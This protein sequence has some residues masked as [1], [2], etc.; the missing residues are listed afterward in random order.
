MPLTR[1]TRIGVYE[2]LQALGAGGM[3]EVY[4]ARDTRLDRVVALK[5]L[6]PDRVP[7]DDA[8]RRFA[9]EARAAS[10]L[11]HPNIV[12]VFDV[13]SDSGIEYIAMEL[14]PGVSLEHRIPRTGMS[15][16]D[17]LAVAIP[18]A[19][20]LAKAHAAGLVH[21]DLKPGNVMVTPDGVVKVLDFGLAKATQPADAAGA[22]SMATLAT[23]TARGVVL[24]TSAYMS[25][26]QAEAK[27]VDAR[28][29]I[30]SFGVML[31]E[32]A[33]GRR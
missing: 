6:L 8:R 5:V 11:N 7:D 31:Y 9:Q 28:S 27:T 2:I 10:S 15:V 19:G 33:T 29:D 32:M 25:P 30:F 4:R 1:G 14:V 13:G 21:R 20:A 18:V 3:G 16:R 12:T 26:E 17:L 22:A 23:Q 24:G